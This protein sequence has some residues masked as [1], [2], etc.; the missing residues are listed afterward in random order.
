M[1]A[2]ETIDPD[3]PLAVVLAPYAGS[4]VQFRGAVLRQLVGRG[5]RVLVS[6]PN[7]TEALR[8]ALSAIGATCVASRL[9]RTGLNPL[10]DWALAAELRHLMRS[11]RPSVVIATGI[12][13]I[14]YGLPAARMAGVPTRVAFFAGLGSIVRPSGLAQRTISL[15]V[16]P[17]L[18]RALRAATHVVTQNPDDTAELEARVGRCLCT[19]PITTEGSGVDLSHFKLAPIATT[20]M[21]LMMAR[22]VPEK[23]IREFMAAAQLVRQH[24]PSVRFALA[25]FFETG[26]R[27]LKQDQFL[28]ECGAYGIDYL[29]HIDD[30]RALL[31]DCSVFVLPTYYGEG[32]P[33]S[34]QEALAMGRP[35]ITT[36]NVGCR[37]AIEDGVHGHIV[38]P[39]DHLALAH[40]IERV[41]S[42][43]D[44]VELSRICRQYAEKRYCSTR[45]ASRWLD[46]I[47]LSHR[48]P[49]E[50]RSSMSTSRGTQDLR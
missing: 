4:V 38:P 48:V 5:Y 31:R 40:A 29:G 20:P 35:V 18:R 26:L 27:G 12:K 1:S 23:G 46:L 32:R 41:L 13:A 10:A 39:R 11:V 44:P 21:V 19:A 30:V 49:R 33:R 22:I 34:I 16:Q 6:V 2:N 42:N 43:T 8:D 24:N 7:P 37:D 9:S 25:G 17:L 50:G 14:L 3:R 36:D 47:H 45:I 28:A 15:A